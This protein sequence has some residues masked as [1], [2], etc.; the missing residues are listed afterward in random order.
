MEHNKHIKPISRGTVIDHLPAWSALR[1][2]KFLDLGEGSATLAINVPSSRLGK[3]DLVF[4][5]ERVL[6]QKD[7]GRIGLIAKKASLNVIEDNK[8]IR[9]EQLSIPEEAAGILKCVNPECI[10]NHEEIRTRFFIQ[11][12]PLQ[13]K[14]YYCEYVQEEQ[15]ILEAIK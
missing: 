3:K 12:S 13:A 11:Q 1:I 2:L 5:S 8:V 15:D 9:K 14:C 7:I 6:S 4:L 10:T